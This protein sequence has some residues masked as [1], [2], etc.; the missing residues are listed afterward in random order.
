MIFNVKNIKDETIASASV[1]LRTEWGE[2]YLT[3][4]SEIEIDKYS[5]FLLENKD[6]SEDIIKDFYNISNLRCSLP[7]SDFVVEDDE[8]PNIKLENLCT[9]F[10]DFLQ[11]ISR[12]YKLKLIRS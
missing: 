5:E 4:N 2:Q 11:D 6:L 3:V 10:G 12:K 7:N 8:Y 1:H 9:T